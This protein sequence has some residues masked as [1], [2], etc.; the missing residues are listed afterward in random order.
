MRSR[1]GGASVGLVALLLGVLVV[2]QFRSQSSGTGLELLT[3]QELT[4]LVGNLNTRN[5]QL[6]SE[7]A[8]LRAQATALEEASGRGVGS[9]GQLE[10]DLD[11]VRAWAGLDPLAGRG[12]LLTISGPLDGEA[13]EDLLNELRNASAEAIA[14]GG[15]RVA[16]GTVVAGPADGLT[17]E[18]RLLG[19]A[20]EV[21]AIGD[22]AVLTASLTRSGGIVA[23]LTARY[24]A[25]RITVTPIDALA[26][27]ATTRELVPT[28]G[29]PRG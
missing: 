12:V 19:D 15:I 2:I 28:S 21:E 23:Q 16:A 25:T 10:G 18:G 26:L 8:S 29:R 9:V 11:R 4:V 3:T 13:V 17:V 20:F 7:V 27:P 1:Y 14:V 5:E 22:P 24:P 6:R